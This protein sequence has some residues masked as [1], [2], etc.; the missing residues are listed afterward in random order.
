MYAVMHVW[1]VCTS[2]FLLMPSLQPKISSRLQDCTSGKMRSGSI[3]MA[4][5][6]PSGDCDND[7]GDDSDNGGDDH[8]SNSDDKQDDRNDDNDYITAEGR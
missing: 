4:P 2:H 8:D 6:N 3:G 5:W 1:Y 7:D